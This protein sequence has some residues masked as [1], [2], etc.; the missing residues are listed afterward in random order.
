[1]FAPVAETPGFGEALFRLVRELRG[2]GYDLGDLGPLLDGAT[3][4]PEKAGSLAEILV[5][6][7]RRRAGFYGP[8]D[9]LVAGDPARLDGLGLLV[10]GVLDMPPA[11]E[12]LIVG[13][14]ERM[15]VVV[16]LPD[17]PAAAEAP[18]AALGRRLLERGG[19][20]ILA[21]A[22]PKLGTALGQLREA[23]F[24]PPSGRGIGA[25][26]TVRLVSAPDPAREV[27]AA[28]RACLEWA[29][30]GV[31][32]WEMAVAYRHGEAYRP[33]VEA[34]FIEAGIPLYLHEG[35]PLAERP[36]GRQTLA[37]LDL[38]DTDLSRRSVMDF[39][40]DAWFP[41]ELREQHGGSVPAARWDSV[42]RQA[43]I[44][45]GVEQWAQR[46][47]SLQLDLAGDDAEE[48]QPDWVRDRIADAGE[49]ARFIAEL[50]RRL[51]ARPG[52]ATWA[53]HLN[54]LRDLLARYVSRSEAIVVA[55]RGLERFTAL[56]AE[57]EFDR[58]L[59][60]VRRAL[61]TL[62]S[63]DV[64]DGRA[65]LFARLGVNVVAVNSLPGIEFRRLWILGATERSFPAF[66]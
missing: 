17:V 6:F 40:T 39:L 10:W 60:V 42:S 45:S 3:D 14:A 15:P 11:L 48:D 38:Y 51:G 61:G 62:R 12:R 64:L 16:Y 65:G 24:T 23:L 8:D 34:V 33:L 28:A 9:A 54:Y 66:R 55:L 46:L 41:E 30:D 25:D 49:L 2:A 18:V 7:E 32:L 13:V 37:L 29:S 50:D 63:E 47:A 52:R 44:V 56:E 22:M 59:E 21:P 20:E 5:S 58:L 4:A 43:G 57:V 53:T 35:S 26:G 19:S 1:M 36:L 27:R 31:E